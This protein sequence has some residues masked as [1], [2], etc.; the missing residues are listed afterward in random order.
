MKKEITISSRLFFTSDLYFGHLPLMK[1]NNRP[2]ENTE[3]MDSA[4]I[5]NWNR[6]VPADGVVYVLGDIGHS[7][8]K[9]ARIQEIFGRLKGKKILIRGNHD[10]DY[11]EDALRTI[12]EEIHDILYLRVRDEMTDS[13]TYMV[14][15]H[16][17]M[18]DWQSSFRGAWQ[19]FG[20]VHTRDIPEFETF[21]KNLFDTQ[22]DVGVD[23]NKF[24]P[25]S[26]SELKTA[27]EK[28]K[29]ESGFKTNN[30][31]L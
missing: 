15:C 7:E 3:E 21:K 2:F 27:I 18:V 31:F 26:F 8:T 5:D 14:L 13:Y 9:I 30:Y 11:K 4:L 28:Q 29:E 6:V 16:Y 1:F 10:E 12:F 24:T 23:Q 25:L 17:P 19:L 22:Y 20:H